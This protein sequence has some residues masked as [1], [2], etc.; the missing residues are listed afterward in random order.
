M[1]G[2]VVTRRVD[3]PGAGHDIVLTV[4]DTDRVRIVSIT[5]ELTAPATGVEVAPYL[6]LTDVNGIMYFGSTARALQKS[7]EVIIYTWAHG[8]VVPF[9]PTDIVEQTVAQPFPDLWLE[10]G[11]NVNIYAGNIGEA[12]K[13]QN[14]A[15]RAI[16]GDHWKRLEVEEQ[17]AAAFGG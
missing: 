13:W 4:S 3:A 6:T 12:Q 9:S 15:Y 17:V 11:D 10:P 1:R 2:V 8:V 5:A 14:I 16:V 7:D